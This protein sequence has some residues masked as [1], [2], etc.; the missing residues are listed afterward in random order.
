MGATVVVIIVVTITSAIFGN[1][2]CSGL[3]STV[4]ERVSRIK[5]KGGQYE[6]S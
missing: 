5:L 2:G 6:H 4:L 1:S 3:G